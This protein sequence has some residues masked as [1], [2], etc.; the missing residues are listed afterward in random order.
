MPKK[1][2]AD[3]DERIEA[4]IAQHP[5]GIG[6]DA[7]HALLAEVV[8]RRTLGLDGFELIVYAC[9]ATIIRQRLNFRG[10]ITTCIKRCDNTFP[11]SRLTG[12]LGMTFL[13]CED[14]GCCE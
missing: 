13:L 5:D 3:L 7:L 9:F 14:G 2:P 11:T 6:T 12:L 8:S 4:L 10:R 1:L